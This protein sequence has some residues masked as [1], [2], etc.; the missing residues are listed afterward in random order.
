MRYRTQ[1]T[2]TK[3]HAKHKHAPYVVRRLVALGA[4]VVLVNEVGQLDGGIVNAPER[5][6]ILDILFRGVGLNL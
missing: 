4:E 6:Q 3:K 2:K 1:E 5:Q